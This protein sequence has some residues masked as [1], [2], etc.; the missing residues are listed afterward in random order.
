MPK[1]IHILA[2]VSVC[3]AL[4]ALACLAPA[5][6]CGYYGA[7]GKYAGYGYHSL[8]KAA[9]EGFG[10]SADS[11]PVPYGGYSGTGPYEAKAGPW[12]GALYFPVFI[13]II[14][15]GWLIATDR[16]I[17]PSMMSGIRPAR[18]RQSRMRR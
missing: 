6:P 9:S 14:S 16:L 4:G 7:D 5:Y 11:V 15:L 17:R 18:T 12:I 8:A 10:W 3:V 13:A 1:P 2:A